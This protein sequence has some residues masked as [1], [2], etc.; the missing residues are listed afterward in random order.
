MKPAL[1]FLTALIASAVHAAPDADTLIAESDRA[2][3]G[4]LPGLAWKIEVDSYDNHGETRQT[5]AAITRDT[6]TRV[7]YLAPAK[8]KGQ[9]VLMLGRNMWFSRPGLHKPVPLSPRQRLIGQ[10]ANG[11]I[12]ATDYRDDYNARWGGEE[13]V[14]GERCAVLELTARTKNVTYDRI[15]Y[16]IST[17]RQVGVKAE[18]FTVSGKLF[19]TAAFDYGNAIDYEG[20]T[21]PFISRMLI[22][23]AINPRNRTTMTYSGVQVRR[24]DA[25]RFELAP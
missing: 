15:R 13:T 2:R 11:D 18:F 12:A 20:K 10:A 8:M 14:A 3:G 4:H 21:Y 1:L 7:D 24:P 22:V 25:S 6:D 16:W 23:D 19:K 5:M 9:S 17:G